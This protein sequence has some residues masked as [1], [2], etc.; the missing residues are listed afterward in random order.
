MEKQTVYIGTVVIGN[1]GQTND[2]RR[3]VEFVGEMLGR[4]TEYGYGRHGNITD[5]RGVTE[6]LYRTEDGRL[7]VHVDDWS[8]WRGEPS[9]ETLHEVTEADL[10]P[11][12]R[13]E[14]LGAEAGYGRAL[15]LDEAVSRCSD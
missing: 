10:Q 11:G 5:T 9:V 4:R 15:T 2:S 12:G 1:G 3:A 13:F 6:T 14:D 8:R 7:I